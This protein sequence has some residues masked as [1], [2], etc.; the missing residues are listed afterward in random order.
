VRVTGV[1]LVTDTVPTANV[2]VEAPAAT[3]TLAGTLTTPGLLFVRVTTAPPVG[4]APVNVTAPCAELPPT[5]VKGL[6]VRAD[7][8]WLMFAT[9]YQTNLMSGKT[10]SFVLSM[11]IALI[12]E[13]VGDH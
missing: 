9:A 3:V 6:T 7:N 8:E 1:E 5:T 12:T 4:A 13:V 10:H 2:A 11:T